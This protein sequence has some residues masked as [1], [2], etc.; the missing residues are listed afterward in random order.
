MRKPA[1]N[2]LANSLPVAEISVLSN[3][4]ENGQPVERNDGLGSEEVVWHSDNSYIEKP[5]AG[6]TLYALEIPADGSG[7][8]L[9]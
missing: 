4:D 8:Y 1:R 7:K 6:S 3:L 5:P 2:Q 9:F